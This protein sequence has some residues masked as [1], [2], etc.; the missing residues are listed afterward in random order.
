MKQQRFNDQFASMYELAVKLS[1]QAD[2]DAL[3]VMLEGPTDWEELRK[4]A[5]REKILAAADS[6][7]VLEGA[8]E[9]GL[10]TVV[11]ELQDAPVFEKLTQAL[12]EGVA[13]E[14]LDPN[15][16]VVA[17]YS[18]FDP[19][20]IDSISFIRLDEHLGR[21]TA[22]D[23]RQI[24]TSV[25][26]ETL[27]CVVDLAVDIGREGREGKP[28]G[29]LFVVGDT[30]KVLTQSHPAGYDPVKGYG[31]KER[32]LADARVREAVKEVA[33][34]DGAFIVSPD[35]TVEKACQIVNADHVN[36]TLSKGLGSR[37]WAAAA[38]SKDTNAIAVTVSESNGTVRLFKKGEVI[39]R[40]EPFR[41]AMKW[42]DFEYEPP[43]VGSD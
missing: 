2:A 15:S 10:A 40:V 5:G 16:E 8:T 35:G 23:L 4:R 39:L 38:I 24:E 26:L 43:S 13:D 11:L 27:K 32:S 19:G 14:I 42:K 31:R 18:G 34:L 36:I 12:L 41:L 22:R 21:L 33:P 6:E 28:V 30:R 25:P 1:K 37:H 7:E 9:A 3:L 17:V 29:T 20:T